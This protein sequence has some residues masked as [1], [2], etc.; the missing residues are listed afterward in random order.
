VCALLAVRFG[1]QVSI[2]TAARYLKRWGLTPQKPLRRAY[3]QAPKAVKQWLAHTYPL[4]RHRDIR[5][6]GEIHWGDERGLP[7]HQTGRSFGRRGHTPVIPPP[8]RALSVF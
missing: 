1:R 6:G 8:T 3:A 7:D 4:I 2:C 5:E